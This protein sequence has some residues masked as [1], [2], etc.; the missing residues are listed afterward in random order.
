LI[1]SIIGLFF[2]KYYKTLRAKVFYYEADRFSATHVYIKGNGKKNEDIVCLISENRKNY[3]VFK[4]LKYEL[5]EN[6]CHIPVAIN[7]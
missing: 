3:F 5:L 7:Y 4:N 1:V 6:G 2:L